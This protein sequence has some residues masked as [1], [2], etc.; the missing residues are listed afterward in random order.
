MTQYIEYAIY[1]LGLL[2][3]VVI[4]ALSY[5]FFIQLLFYAAQKVKNIE[6][7]WLIAQSCKRRAETAEDCLDEIIDV[8]NARAQWIDRSDPTRLER[9]REIVLYIG[10]RLDNIDKEHIDAMRTYHGGLSESLGNIEKSTD[11]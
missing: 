9:I 6:Y 4:I 3:L 11:E 5:W 7:G 8:C 1:G 10:E 2:A